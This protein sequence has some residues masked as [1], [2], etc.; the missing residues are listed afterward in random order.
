MQLNQGQEAAVSAVLQFLSSPDKEFII[1]GPAGVGKTFLMQYI[2]K[3]VLKEYQDMHRLL[4][5]PTVDYKVHLTATTN[6]AAE[7]LMETTG[8]GASTIHSFL[9]LRVKDNY[10]TGTQDITTTN[11]WQI[12]TKELIFI[13]E[14]SMI[15][16]KLH[17][18]ILTGTDAS[19]KIIYL[20]DHCQLAPVMEQI[21]P[22]YVQPKHFALLTEPVRNAD[23]PALMDLCNQL[24]NTV[25]TGEFKPIDPVP[26]V[27]EYLDDAQAQQLIDRDFAKESPHNRILCYTNEKVQEYNHY[28]RNLRGY[29]QLFVG[30]ELLICNSAIQIGSTFLR[31]EQEVLVHSA[32]SHTDMIAVGPE[33]D[34]VEMEVQS[35]VLSDPRGNFYLKTRVPANPDH[36]KALLKYYAGQKRWPVY[37]NLKN[38]FP[39]LRPKDA[40]TVHKAQG[41]TYDSVILDLANI[42]RCTQ[43]DQVARMLYVGVS[44]ARNK[45]YLYGKLPPRF[46]GSHPT[47][48]T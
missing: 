21:S 28:I 20:G 15:D 44:R 18:Y 3:N 35:L 38:G 42:G 13:D 30:G 10:Q 24:R 40:A 2:T 46:Q 47:T 12:H 16:S 4:G 48:G 9:G 39:D 37:F 1:S 7:V 23:Q 6:K 14:A 25:E 29:P 26:G 33:S 32:E 19:C 31:V 5:L 11:D 43:N 36:F 41:S 45:V 27:I 34:P 22:V 17:K 8:V